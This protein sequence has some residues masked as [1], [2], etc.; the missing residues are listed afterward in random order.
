MAKEKDNK[1]PNFAE[2]ERKRLLELARQARK[3]VLK[4]KKNEESGNRTEGNAGD[5]L[6]DAE[7]KA[8]EQGTLKTVWGVFQEAWNK[9]GKDFKKSV[10]FKMGESVFAGLN[11]YC[12]NLL[13]GSLP[14]LSMVRAARRQSFLALRFWRL[15]AKGCLTFAG[16]RQKWRR[17]F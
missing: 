8:K 5:V 3:T 1:I 13:F 12:Q 17:L 10:G 4:L 9:T 15:L 6:D 14:G 2:Y 16:L 11:P 7:K